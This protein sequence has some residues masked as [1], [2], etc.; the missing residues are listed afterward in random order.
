MAQYT[1]TINYDA[2]PGT[3]ATRTFSMAPTDPL[4]GDFEINDVI[5][6]GF[7]GPGKVLVAMLLAG[8]KTPSPPNTPAVDVIKNLPT[9]FNGGQVNPINLIDH[10]V[11]TIT[12]PI[13]LWGFT[14]ALAVWY[15]GNTAFHY[16]PDPELHVGSTPH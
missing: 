14:V 13:G 7:S 10:P 2:T 3:L 16:L 11:L 9:P 6:V 15:N 8:P 12:G 4:A 5:T 1:L